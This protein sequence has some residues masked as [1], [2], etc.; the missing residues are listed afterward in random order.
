[1][2]DNFTEY[3]FCIDKEVNEAKLEKISMDNLGYNIKIL[4]K[5]ELSYVEKI[6]LYVDNKIYE[7]YDY[8]EKSEKMI[9]KEI[10]LSLEDIRFYQEVYIIVYDK[11]GNYKKSESIILNVDNINSIVDLYRFKDIVNNKICDFSNK[12]VYLKLNLNLDLKNVNDWEGISGFKGEFNGNL[13]TISGFYMDKD[14]E[15][16]ALFADNYGIIKNLIVSR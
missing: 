7:I 15:K 14:T 9:E 8:A 1:M 6:E 12:I 2:Y 10:N 11:L 3:S 13:H 16:T 4:G 5:E